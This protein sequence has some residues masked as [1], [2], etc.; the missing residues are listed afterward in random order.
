MPDTERETAKQAHALIT[1]FQRIYKTQGKG[2]RTFNRY[3]AKWGMIDAITD[4]GVERASELIEYYFRT[5]REVYTIEDFYR[6]YDKL[7]MGEKAARQDATRRA[8]I[9]EATAKLVRE[10]EQSVKNPQ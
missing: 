1:K 2:Q 6:S 9:R 7:D 5:T 3:A 8:T 4:L 10:R